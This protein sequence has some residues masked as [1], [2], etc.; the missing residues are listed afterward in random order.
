MKIPSAHNRLAVRTV[1][2]P[3]CGARAGMKCITWKDG[4]PK[5][6]VSNHL[7]RVDA[8]KAGETLP[9]LRLLAS[10]K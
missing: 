6:R 1:D 8:F 3:E 4:K 7:S 2:C 5:Y 9:L 10:K